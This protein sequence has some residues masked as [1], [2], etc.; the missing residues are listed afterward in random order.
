MVYSICRRFYEADLY[1]MTPLY[2]HAYIYEHTY[3]L[4]S[5][6]WVGLLFS[7]LEERRYEII[8][9]S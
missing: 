5:D 4:K 2:I 9:L 1:D 6:I 3:D 7:E 8:Y